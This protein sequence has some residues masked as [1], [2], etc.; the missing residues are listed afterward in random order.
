[1]KRANIVSGKVENTGREKFLPIYVGVGGSRLY[2]RPP[3]F[4]VNYRVLGGAT[5]MK[6]RLTI[7]TLFPDTGGA[8][9]VQIKLAFWRTLVV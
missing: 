9:C 2:V 6:N 7:P 8:W 1:V 5:L 4:E 3:V